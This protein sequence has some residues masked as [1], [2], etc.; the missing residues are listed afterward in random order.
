MRN[1]VRERIAQ[2]EAAG[3]AREGPAWSPAQWCAAL[4]AA[5][6]ERESG[7]RRFPARAGLSSLRDETPRRWRRAR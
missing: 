6:L 2:A 5:A 1:T 4:A 7:A 3:F